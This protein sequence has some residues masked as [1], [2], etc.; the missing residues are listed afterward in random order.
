[1]RRA[2]H[3]FFAL[4]LT[5]ALGGCYVYTVI[6]VTATPSPVATDTPAPVVTNTPAATPTREGS[7]PPSPLPAT[8]GGG[9]ISEPLN[10]NSWM[11]SPATSLSFGDNPPRFMEVPA[12]FRFFW[13]SGGYTPHGFV[14]VDA[15]DDGDTVL[16][17]D[18]AWIAGAWCYGQDGLILESGARYLLRAVYN[19]DLVRASGD[20]QTSDLR[21]YAI[22]NNASGGTT[23]ETY[24]QDVAGDQ[25]TGAEALWVIESARPAPM[26]QYRM[27]MTVQWADFSRAVLEWDDIEVRRLPDGYGDVVVEW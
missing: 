22:L 20:F 24:A 23:V 21:F 18:F 16:R 7:P 8:Q 3:I 6:E 10:P 25:V 11:R 13:V 9:V 14:K 4:I 2:A 27:C 26:L 15:R 12:S 5:L 19:A 1:M 17:W